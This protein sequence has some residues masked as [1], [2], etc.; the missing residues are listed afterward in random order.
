MNGTASAFSSILR[1]E[2]ALIPATLD[3]APFIAD[4]FTAVRPDDPVDP[5]LLRHQWVSQPT[6]DTNERF[7]ALVKGRPLGFAAN[8]HPAWE[9][10]PERYGRV[11]AELHPEV[12]TRVLLDRLYELIE[13]RSLADG[14]RTFVERGWEDDALRLDV[15]GRRG[16]EEKRRE[17]FWELDLVANRERLGAM[18]EASRARTRA[19]GIEIATLDRIADPEKYRKLWRMSEEAERDIPTTV[20]HVVW[21]LEAFLAFLRSP[22]LHEERI[23]VARVGDEVVGVS[24][25]SYPPVRGVVET[26]WTATA[27]SVRGRGVARALKC[28]T[29]LQAIALGV[30][31]VRT[32]NDGQNAPI[33]HINETMGYR[34]RGEQLQLLK[35]T[36]P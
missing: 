15:L 22:G 7:I 24:M 8:L 28:A 20:P 4:L 3:D 2:L 17:R 35:P 18:A 33:L 23:W 30:D 13:G 36:T 1:D 19:G 32:D 10:L 5:V 14:T 12:R 11:K 27:R 26:E 6:D 31:R 34:R 29:L 16:Y 9:K 21:P 25:L